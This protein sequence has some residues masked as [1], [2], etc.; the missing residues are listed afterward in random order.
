[1]LNYIYLVIGLQCYNMTSEMNIFSHESTLQYKELKSFQNNQEFPA[2]AVLKH[3]NK[4]REIKEK[5]E[6]RKRE[7]KIIRK[8]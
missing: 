3:V 2:E 6:Q 8:Y 1:M 7:S 4:M 5:R